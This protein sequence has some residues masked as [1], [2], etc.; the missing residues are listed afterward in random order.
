VNAQTVFRESNHET[1]LPAQ[2][3]FATVLRSLHDSATT[4]PF[5]LRHAAALSFRF[6]K[7][8]S[9]KGALNEPCKKVSRVHVTG[10][11]FSM[12]HVLIGG[13]FL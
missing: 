1:L 11:G 8:R 10:K 3:R 12:I 9:R 2:K 4:S 6:A 7:N 13:I 5:G